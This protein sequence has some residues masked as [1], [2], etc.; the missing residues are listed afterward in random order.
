MILIMPLKH[1]LGEASISSRVSATHPCIHCDSIS[2][3]CSWRTKVQCPCDLSA[4][5]FIKNQPVLYIGNSWN[6]V[7]AEDVINAWEGG[8]EGG[9]IH[10]CSWLSMK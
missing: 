2:D 1:A 10:H 7:R 9:T 8:R 5:L 3:L 4:I 6:G